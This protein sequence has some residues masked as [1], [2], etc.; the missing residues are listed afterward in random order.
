M[1]RP[2]RVLL[3]LVAFL[4]VLVV[5][6][7]HAEVLHDVFSITAAGWALLP[8]ISGANLVKSF[9]GQPYAGLTGLLLVVAWS[10]FIAYAFHKVAL[11]ITDTAFDWVSFRWG[12]V[13]GFLPGI[14]LGWRLWINLAPQFTLVTCCLGG[15]SL[16][17]ALLGLFMGTAWIK[18]REHVHRDRC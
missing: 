15:G 10:S 6:L 12:F 13:I 16:G 18:S 2:I 17:G 1:R 14:L 9:V 11:V 7:H 5:V 4:P 3:P 8:A